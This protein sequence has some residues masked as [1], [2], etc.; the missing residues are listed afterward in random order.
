MDLEMKEIRAC[1]A[2]RGNSLTAARVFSDGVNWRAVVICK[3]CGILRDGSEQYDDE[4]EA[5]LVLASVPLP[6]IQGG[7][8]VRWQTPGCGPRR[9]Q[10]EGTIVAWVPAFK[11]AGSFLP[12]D[13]DRRMLR[14][15]ALASQP[16]YLIAVDRGGVTEYMT[17]PANWVEVN[18]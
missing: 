15:R 6:P 5:R 9:C 18:R 13:G 4:A 11:D 16:R 14:S 12:D 7:V 17:A 10:R 2:C 1:P 3:N 8:R